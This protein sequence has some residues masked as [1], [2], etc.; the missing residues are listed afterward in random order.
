MKKIISNNV[1]KTLK[2]GKKIGNLLLKGNTIAL[3]GE[4]GAGKTT[5]IKGIASGLG[6][7]D[8]KY[9]NSPSFVI[10]KEYKGRLPIYH[11]D[12]HRLDNNSDLDTLGYEEYFYGNGVTLI[13]WADKIKE[14]LPPEY[15]DIHLSINGVNSRVIELRS[16]GNTYKNI[17]KGIKL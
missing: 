9:V 12:I 1:D 3:T 14:V 13:E 2:L 15:L 6:V 17:I 7:K 10:I 16:F 8:I 11:F 5:L 4:F